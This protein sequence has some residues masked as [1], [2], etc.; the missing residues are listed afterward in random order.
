MHVYIRSSLISYTLQ[1][2][3]ISHSAFPHFPYFPFGPSIRNPK[4]APETNQRC[5]MPSDIDASQTRDRSDCSSERRRS[6]AHAH[7]PRKK[8]S[9]EAEMQVSRSAIASWLSQAA[10]R[11]MEAFLIVEK[12]SKQPTFG[13]F[14]LPLT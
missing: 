7:A 12:S 14:F 5:R 6:D 3:R 8:K 10:T 11:D 13:A 9:R 1:D 4:P 2:T